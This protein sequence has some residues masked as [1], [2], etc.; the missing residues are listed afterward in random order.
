M[1]M[2]L[3]GNSIIEGVYLRQLAGMNEAHKDI[4]DICAVEGLIEQGIL[5]DG[6]RNNH[7]YN[8]PASQPKHV[9]PHK[10]YRKTTG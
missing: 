6:G 4:A 9:L 7:F 5:S 3:Q 8:T 2:L 10:L 1:R